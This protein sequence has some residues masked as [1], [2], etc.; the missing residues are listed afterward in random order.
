[1][2]VVVARERERERERGMAGDAVHG[3]GSTLGPAAVLGCSFVAPRPP[4]CTLI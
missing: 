1:M 3:T 4:L 2:N